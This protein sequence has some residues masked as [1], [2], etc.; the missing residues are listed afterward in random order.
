[1]VDK[2]AIFNINGFSGAVFFLIF[3]LILFVVLP[4]QVFTGFG[5]LVNFFRVAQ[6][7][8]WPY[9]QYWVEFPPV[10]PFLSELVYRISGGIEWKYAYILAGVFSVFDAGSIVL[11]WELTKKKDSLEIAKLRLTIYVL[12]LSLFPYGWWYF[13]P[14]VV[15]FFLLALFFVMRGKPI[16]SG[17]AMAAGF[18][19]KVFP[20]LV[21]IPAWL[22]FRKK[23]FVIFAGVFV[24]LIIATLGFLWKVSPEFTRASLASQYS[25]GSWETVWAL[26]DGNPGTGN[27]ENSIQIEIALLDPPPILYI[28]PLEISILFNGKIVRI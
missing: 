16:H 27:L 1:M 15:F 19:L 6:I 8:G 14:L 13:E 21:I 12:I 26:L 25:K 17:I 20:V 24:V 5:D 23:S 7:P 10:F 4:Y 9:L 28:F 18:L 22:N 11:F 2:K 3:R